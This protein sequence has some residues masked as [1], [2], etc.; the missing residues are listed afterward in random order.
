[1]SSKPPL[2]VFAQPRTKLSG[3]ARAFARAAISPNTKRAYQTQWRQWCEYATAQKVT[4]LPADP[5]T[6]ANWFAER[7]SI[8]VA[9][10]D[11]ATTLPGLKLA[12]LRSALAAIR[13][14]H[15]AANQN[16]D[17]RD[18]AI[19]LVLRGIARTNV[20]MPRQAAPVRSALVTEIIANLG[21]SARDCRDAALLA[22]GYCFARRRSELAA[23]DYAELG[24][25]AAVLSITA[26]H[27][28]IRLARAKGK[29]DGVDLVY[30]VPV[31]PN[32]L[33]VK[34]IERWIDLANIEPGQPILRRVNKSGAISPHRLDPQSIALIVKARIA[35]HL[36]RRGLSKTA[37]LNQARRFS[38][39]SLR[40]GFAVSSAEAGASV[41]AIQN[42]LGHKSPA[43][44]ARYA[45]TAEQ[46]RTSPHHL[47][48]VSITQMRRLPRTAQRRLL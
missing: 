23:L 15:Q 17:S 30:V 44:A 47:P 33:A 19:A 7:A 5:V 2:N 38:G 18:P 36:E 48:G 41:V 24:T 34:A 10:P 31:A 32:R 1:M 25:G 37:A 13:F 8:S 46:A 16:F 45:R 12:T 4:A 40:V 35:E 3:P 26:S 39:H 28:E 21:T 6:V 27:L 22:L 9:S 14:A 43:M 20:D 11:E 29:R 42:A